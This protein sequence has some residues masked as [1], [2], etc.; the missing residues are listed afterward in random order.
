MTF[1][2]CA[3]AFIEAHRASWRSEKHLRDWRAS[4]ATHASPIIGRMPVNAIDTGHVMR[5]LEPIWTEKPVTAGRIRARIEAI[6]D[7]AAARGHRSNENSACWKKLRFLLPSPSKVHA[8]RHHAAMPYVEVPAFMRRLASLNYEAARALQ[9]TILT[10]CRSGEVLGAKGFEI[11]IAAR[12]W[13]VP[14]ARMK[15]NRLHRVPLSEAAMA[16]LGAKVSYDT[17]VFARPDG[18]PLPETAM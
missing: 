1:D 8:V 16:V 7:L 14:A 6:L 3:S 12:V 2:Q 10:A 11:D 18:R 15:G 4:L 5:V 13:T 17:F 9:F